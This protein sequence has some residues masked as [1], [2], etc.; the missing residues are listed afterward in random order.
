MERVMSNGG[1]W[2][3]QDY[4]TCPHQIEDLKYDLRIYILLFGLNPLRI[5]IHE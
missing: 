4:L 5:Y 1:G 2:V 3:A